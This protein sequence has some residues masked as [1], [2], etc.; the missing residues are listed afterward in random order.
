MR[1]QQPGRVCLA[2]SAFKSD[3]S[4]TR[5][6]EAAARVESPPWEHVLVIDS[7]GSGKIPELIAAR[8]WKNV[9]YRSFPT[10]LGSA[11]NFWLRLKIPSEQGFDWVY[12]INHDGLVAPELIRQLLKHTGED[13]GAVYPIRRYTRRRDVYD[14]SGLSPLPWPAR[15]VVNRPEGTALRAHWGAS[16]GALFSMKAIRGGVRVLNELWLGWEDL[17]LGW[18][19]DQAG[20]SQLLIPDA[21]LDDDYEYLEEKMAFRQLSEKPS[22]YAYYAVR[23]LLLASRTVRPGLSIEAAAGARVA[24]EF[25]GLLLRSKK[26]ERFRFALQGLWAGVRGESGKGQKP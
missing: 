12:A 7:L 20:Y 9:E 19:L 16:N 4:I 23:N 8:G 11:G 25:A 10:N 22:W 18:S 14:V 13:V 2:I 17:A 24:L 3:E 21:V 5:L 1:A 26:R 6:L 15:T